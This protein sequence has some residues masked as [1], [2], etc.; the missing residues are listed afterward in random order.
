MSDVITY[1]LSVAIELCEQLDKGT[2]ETDAATSRIFCNVSTDFARKLKY[3]RDK[4]QEKFNNLATEHM[5]V[6]NKLAGERDEAREKLENEIKW[7]HR[8]HKEL[9]E[10]QCKLL[11]IEYDQLKS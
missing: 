8:T 10:A 1:P 3:E 4:I 7:H 6:V 5:L 11:D 9:V 2:P